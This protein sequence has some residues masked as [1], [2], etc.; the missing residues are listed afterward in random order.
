[1]QQLMIVV[2]AVSYGMEEH[3][4]IIGAVVRHKAVNKGVWTPNPK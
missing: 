3:E 1:M 2:R 4:P